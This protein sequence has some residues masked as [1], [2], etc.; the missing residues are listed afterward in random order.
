LRISVS[1]FYDILD[2]VIKPFRLSSGIADIRDAI[3]LN[4]IVNHLVRNGNDVSISADNMPARLI[5]RVAIPDSD[6]CAASLAQITRCLQE[7][8]DHMAE[9]LAVVTDSKYDLIEHL[10]SYLLDPEAGDAC[11]VRGTARSKSQEFVPE[12]KLDEPLLGTAELLHWAQYWVATKN[13]CL[14]WKTL[15]PSEPIPTKIPLPSYPFVLER[16]WYQTKEPV[17][18]IKNIPK[19]PSIAWNDCWLS[20]VPIPSSI[21]VLGVVIEHM[22]SEDSGQQIYLSEVLF[23]PPIMLEINHEIIH[24]KLSAD[25]GELVQGLV[26]ESCER[27]LIQA[28]R[29][30][31]KKFINTE[32]IPYDLDAASIQD[33]IFYEKLKQ[34]GLNYSMLGRCV[35]SVDL[36]SGMLVL[37][38]SISRQGQSSSSFWAILLSTILAGLTHLLNEDGHINNLFVP[39]RLSNFWIDAEI[40]STIHKL[41]V[42]WDKDTELASVRAFGIDNKLVIFI[43][44]LDLRL[45][46]KLVTKQMSAEVYA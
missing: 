26:M 32:I 2:K 6:I 28:H 3:T 30:R 1:Q 27:V 39:Y 36:S 31:H 11:R 37:H 4:E 29:N 35:K 40:M 18:P 20:D 25:G 9:R 42:R 16:V 38:L 10:R 12:V 21:L 19:L 5:S 24:R 45:A 22:I 34:I 7:G 43:D 13:A 46:P 17:T 23:G 33:S 8:R 44:G 15:Y 14:I 41:E